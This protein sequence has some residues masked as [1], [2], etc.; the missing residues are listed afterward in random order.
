MIDVLLPFTNEA[1]HILNYNLQI[2]ERDQN[3]KKVLL[4]DNSDSNKLDEFLSRHHYKKVQKLCYEKKD[5]PSTLNLAIQESSADFIGRAD[6]D[7]YCLKDRFSLQLQHIKSRS[8]DLIGMDTYLMSHSYELL[9]IQ[10]FPKRK[11]THLLH[12]RF[13]STICHPTWMATREFF[14]SVGPYD[15]NLK[16]GQDYDLIKKALK[17]NIRI[18]NINLVGIIYCVKGPGDYSKKI[19]QFGTPDTL[20]WRYY[21]FIKHIMGRILQ[22]CL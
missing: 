4:I 21:N 8:L 20:M 10:R 14:E 17:M 18:G 12:S 15:E 3:I 13:Y 2:F 1:L 11:I 5:L 9:R 7:D 6:S 19:K 16:V 22:R